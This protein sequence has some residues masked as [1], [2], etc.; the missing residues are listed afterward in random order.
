MNNP[1]K[2]M[3]I[4]IAI[5]VWIAGY[6]S[7]YTWGEGTSTSTI[8]YSSLI[9]L[10]ILIIWYLIADEARVH[11]GCF[12]RGLLMPTFRETPVLNSFMKYFIISW[13]VFVFVFCILD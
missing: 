9:S 6:I 1:A 10:G 8:G 7:G 13:T 3:G 12:I 11:D 5:V 2:V 4:I